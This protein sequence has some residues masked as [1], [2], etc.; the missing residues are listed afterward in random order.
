MLYFFERIKKQYIFTTIVFFGLILTWIFISFTKL[1]IQPD[2]Y[3]TVAGVPFTTFQLYL[4]VGYLIFFLVTT[5]YFLNPIIRKFPVNPAKIHLLIFLLIWLIAG[6]TWLS[7]PQGKS[8]FAPGPYPPTFVLFPHSDAAV[9]DTGGEMMTLGLPINNGLFTDKP[10]YMFFLGFLHVIFGDDQTQI[11]QVQTIVLALFPAILYLI[12][13]ELYDR[14][15]G[16]FVAMIAIA[17]GGNAISLVTRIPTV[18]VKEMM[19]E[20]PLALSLAILCLLIIRYVKNPGHNI[21]PI[22]IG[23]MLG[24]SIL[25]RPHP[26]FFAP[27]LV[28]MFF[29]LHWKEKSVLLRHFALFFLAFLAVVTPISIS[30]IQHG[31]NPDFMEKI[32]MVLKRGEI[33]NFNSE[34]ESLGE[35][36][37]NQNVIENPSNNPASITPGDSDIIPEPSINDEPIIED[38]A[39]RLVSHFIHNE[40]AIVLSL[41]SSIIFYSDDKTI[42]TSYWTEYPVWDGKLSRGQWFAILLGLLIISFGLAKFM[43]K[44][45]LIG[46]IPLLLHLAINFS[47]SFARSSGGRFLVPADWIIYIYYAVG[48]IEILL[49]VIAGFSEFTKV[50]SAGRLPVAT[51]PIIGVKYRFPFYRRLSSQVAGLVIFLIYGLA[52]A[53]LYIIIPEKYPMKYDIVQVLKQ[54][55]AFSLAE[56]SIPDLKDILNNPEIYSIYGK[57]LYPRFYK[58]NVGEPSANSPLYKQPFDR[59]TFELIS[60]LGVWNVYLPGDTRGKEFVNGSSALVLGCKRDI[61][62]FEAQY[63]II[64]GNKI[65][66]ILTQKSDELNMCH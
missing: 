54:N 30:N 3:W 37:N 55:N 53:N 21:Y 17:R 45:K 38:P 12:G 16:L 11:I 60:P 10:A 33:G 34:K 36:L 29:I 52:L 8:V 46:L 66:Y 41:P 43:T 4:I 44:G 58:A 19:S 23:G 35:E 49:L 1:G 63:V 48:L 31:R 14:N 62:K 42:S 20:M 64:F 9:H 40:V 56:E 18:S 24:I 7:T 2:L 27:F 50:L 25:V 6:T 22:T 26:L 59:L 13:K 47:N 39:T 57:A 51:Q 15:L 61:D 28:V 65:N 5:R 32:N